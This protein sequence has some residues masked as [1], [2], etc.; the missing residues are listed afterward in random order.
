MYM[1]LTHQG[2]S[3]RP[4]LTPFSFLNR[5]E[6]CWCIELIMSMRRSKSDLT[7]IDFDSIEVQDVKSLPTYLNVDIVFVLS[8]VTFWVLD[9]YAHLIDD[10]D[11]CAMDTLGAPPKPP[12]STSI[13]DCHSSVLIVPVICNAL[14]IIVI[15]CTTLMVCTIPSNDWINSNLI[16]CGQ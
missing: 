6:Y 1:R 10:I 4:S 14:V 8:L 13:L 15:T 9:A 16:L 7:L 2:T 3:L 11:K 12:I 5:F